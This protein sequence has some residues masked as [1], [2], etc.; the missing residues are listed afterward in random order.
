MVAPFVVLGELLVGGRVARQGANSPERPDEFATAGQ[1]G[2]SEDQHEHQDQA[3]DDRAGSLRDRQAEAADLDT[4]LKIGEQDIDRT[5]DESAD[6]RTAERERSAEDEHRQGEEGEV[7][8]QLTR[9]HHAIGQREQAT[10][11]WRDA[12]VSE[13]D[14]ESLLETLKRLRVK[15]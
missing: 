13:P 7:D 12:L 9:L 11:I 6:D 15:P 1:S 10:K 3:Q 2:S 5:E 4:R 14:H 8:V